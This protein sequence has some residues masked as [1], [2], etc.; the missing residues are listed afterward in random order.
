MSQIRESFFFFFLLLDK[1]VA[2]EFLY[3][4]HSPLLCACPGLSC[5]SDLVCHV[6]KASSVVT[7]HH[8]LSCVRLGLVVCTPRALSP[9][10]Q[11]LSSQLSRDT[12]SMSRPKL[13]HDL[14]YQVVTWELLS[15]SRSIATE[16][17]CHT[18]AYVV[19]AS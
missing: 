9:R 16:F 19:S 18:R 17:P 7:Q 13:S 3:G 6:L 11:A 2:E 14:E 15:L 1:S 8:A 10:A 4:A 5:M 12:T